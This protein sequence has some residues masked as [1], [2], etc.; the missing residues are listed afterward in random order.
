[1]K[2]WMPYIIGVPLI[3]VGYLFLILIARGSDWHAYP[4]NPLVN[5]LFNT[6]M[7]I[8][9]A[10]GLLLGLIFPSLTEWHHGFPLVFFVGIMWGVV[11]IW[12]FRKLYSRI[13]KRK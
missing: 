7:I 11:L 1:M 3:A 5:V 9:V 4:H 8:L 13:W 6:V 10:P 2:R 12:V